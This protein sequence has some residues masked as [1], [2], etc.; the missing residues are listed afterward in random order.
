MT[1]CYD[2]LR[3]IDGSTLVT[4]DSLTSF[5]GIVS[6]IA[7]SGIYT[8]LVSTTLTSGTGRFGTLY[9]SE[10]Y[11]S[12]I[13][14]DILTWQDP[15]S[16]H[17]VAFTVPALTT[18][19]TYY[20]PKIDGQAG[21]ALMTDGKGNLSFGDAGG[22]SAP[23]DAQ[24]ILNKPNDKLPNS[25]AMSK[26]KPGIVYNLGDNGILYTRTPIGFED[27][28]P[29]SVPEFFPTPPFDNILRVGQVYV[30]TETGVPKPSSILAES[31]N[32]L[33]LIN[34]RFLAANF[35]M[36]HGS[37][38]LRASM[39]ASQFLSNLEEGILKQNAGV[40]ARAIP[41]QDYLSTELTSKNIWIGNAAGKAEMQPLEIA[42]TDAKYIL[43]EPNAALTNA[44]AL[45]VSI[46][47]GGILKVAAGTGVI[48]RATPNQD[49]L[50]LTLTK[51]HIWYGN[52]ENQ[53]EMQEVKLAPTEATFILQTPQEG[54]DKAQAL[55]DTVAPN[56]ILKAVEDGIIEAAIAGEDYATTEQLDEAVR[57]AEAAAEEAEGS[58]TEAAAS[59][60]EATT[61]A[62][63][64]SSSAA[65]AGI[66]AVAAAASAVAAGISAGIAGSK[67]SSAS[68]SAH[69]AANSANNA[70][71]SSASASESA[72]A[73][74]NSATAAATS[75]QQAETVVEGVKGAPY[76]LT[77][78][79]P[80]FINAQNLGVLSTG[81]VK[82][83]VVDG[84]ATLSTVSGGEGIGT[85]SA[86]IAGE[87]L[88]TT[89]N[90]PITS[91]G[92]IGLRKIGNKGYYNM[93]N[94]TVNEY[95]QVVEIEDGAPRSVTANSVVIWGNT[96]G[97]ALQGTSILV[98]N[99]SE[100]SAT[101]YILTNNASGTAITLSAPS[102]G[103]SGSV[104]SYN[105][106]LPPQLG[107][108]GSPLVLGNNGETSFANSLN[109]Y[110]LNTSFIKVG[111]P[112][113]KLPDN[114]DSIL[115]GQD[116]KIVCGAGAG[117]LFV[118]SP[119]TASEGQ[120]TITGPTDITT[121]YNLIF[122]SAPGNAGQVLATD[123]TGQLSFVDGGSS[124]VQSITA[125]AGLSG[126][127]ITSSGTIDIASTGV[128]AGTYNIANITVNAQGQ[129]TT[130]TSA[131]P[132]L[133]TRFKEVTDQ[134]N[135]LQVQL[136]L[137]N[138]DGLL[139]RINGLEQELIM[140]KDG[141]I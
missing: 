57:K 110:N 10:I 119:G 20:L 138:I 100:L 124:G 64:A 114:S 28:P 104:S 15:L 61:A 135:E 9:S 77:T 4:F 39:P 141:K 23:N 94:I 129:V 51:G 12:S 75:A 130:A 82:S 24:Y 37:T 140:L 95:G 128:T 44:Q 123:G 76:V 103:S 69:D 101:S 115:L 8:E 2:E 113:S 91:V 83:T 67:A 120:L 29:L 18:N 54:L 80:L 26:L 139:A 32:D 90:Q 7:D 60:T 73:A 102:A 93:S 31:A 3:N 65:A 59:A 98:T 71:G 99:E 58:A 35:I 136:K 5:R 53:A 49:Y 106:V 117:L 96:T 16:K 25:Q 131:A 132:Q 134:V 42:P 48:S 116:S 108:A 89:D 22:K 52:E 92:T 68:S 78:D 137:L 66:S 47:D 121:S 133:N 40:V 30:G 107:S 56:S 70:A 63:E 127:T 81:L 105:L 6:I 11:A 84:V 43:Q 111:L 112:D 46:P 27:L 62:G 55:S 72:D 86:I 109:L 36:G 79:D 17:Y 1:I 97:S 38:A 21:E 34:G 88:A 33:A 87:G 19:T 45:S 85:V 118:T 50:S 126:G 13:Y 125:G 14:T 74:S 41:N 122:P